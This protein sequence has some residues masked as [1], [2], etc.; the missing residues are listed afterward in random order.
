LRNDFA[1]SLGAQTS[2]AKPCAD[3]LHQAR[4]SCH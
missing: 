1:L 4:R 3:V 2:A